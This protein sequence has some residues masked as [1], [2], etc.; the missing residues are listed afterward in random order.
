MGNIPCGAGVEAGGLAGESGAGN[1]P[2]G[3]GVEAGGLA[4]ESAAVPTTGNAGP[5][6]Q[7]RPRR[8]RARAP[9]EAQEDLG[10]SPRWVRKAKE[11]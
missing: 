4:G 3:A 7:A 2:C 11:S 9:G 8:T 10:L 6:P 1:I 5:E